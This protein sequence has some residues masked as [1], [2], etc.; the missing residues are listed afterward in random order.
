MAFSCGCTF[1]KSKHKYNVCDF[2][3][4]YTPNDS[5]Y[6]LV[7]NL[8]D[9][10]FNK[11]DSGE[12]STF[13][14]VFKGSEFFKESTFNIVIFNTSIPQ[15]RV[16]EASNSNSLAVKIYRS[17]KCFDF[18]SSRDINKSIDKKYPIIIGELR[19]VKEDTE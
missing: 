12:R 14:G 3:K 16:I 13:Y 17:I 18:K 8:T 6:I 9:L 15:N 19:I 10:K 7:V 1:S 4:P 11:L 2:Y 5:L